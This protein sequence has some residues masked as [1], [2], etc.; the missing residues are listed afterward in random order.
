MDCQEVIPEGHAHCWHCEAALA[1]DFFPAGPDDVFHRT[2]E[3]WGRPQEGSE[4]HRK[5]SRR[6][7]LGFFFDAPCPR[8]EDPVGV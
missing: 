7:L 5:Y 8:A 1:D 3:P 6:A 2:R 4:S